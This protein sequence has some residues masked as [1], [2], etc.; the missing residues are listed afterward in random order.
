MA[1]MAGLLGMNSRKDSKSTIAAR[2]EALARLKQREMDTPTRVF[3]EAAKTVLPDVGVL[4][5]AVRDPIGTAKGAVEVASLASPAANAYR[6]YKLATGDGFSVTGAGMEDV[7]QAVEAAGIIPTGKAATLPAKF[8]IDLLNL[9]IRGAARRTTPAVLSAASGG[10]ISGGPKR[11][12]RSAGSRPVAGAPRSSLLPDEGTEVLNNPDLAAENA[13]IDALSRSTE[14]MANKQ[15][16]PVS[17]IPS[18]MRERATGTIWDTHSYNPDTGTYTI[19]LSG[20]ALDRDAI[21]MAAYNTL[22]DGRVRQEAYGNVLDDVPNSP[23][24]I[25]DEFVD[26]VLETYQGYHRVSDSSGRNMPH[27]GLTLDHNISLKNGGS[28]TLDNLFPMKGTTNFK[29]GKG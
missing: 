28:N 25:P 14:E 20:R 21:K 16:I 11:L 12:A 1:G 29:K 5:R 17:A 22:V 2:R 27:F 7:E 19:E 10:I 3:G 9:G 8:G 4:N 23:D 15:G 18:K 24:D 13:A 6:A 26:R